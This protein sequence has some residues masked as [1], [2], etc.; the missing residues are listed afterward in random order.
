MN[1]E[2]KKLIIDAVE[3]IKVQHKVVQEQLEVSRQREDDLPEKE[4]G[5][6]LEC[7]LVLDID[8]LEQID[9]RI[10]DALDN[11]DEVLANL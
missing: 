3:A 9:S 7:R 2:Q 4:T 5:G 6:E 10:Q 1:A 11:I 8:A